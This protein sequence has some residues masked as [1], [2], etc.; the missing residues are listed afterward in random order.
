MAYMPSED[1]SVNDI[2]FFKIDEATYDPKTD[3]FGSDM[4]IA[5]NSSWTVTIP[6]NIKPG[7]YV[8]RHEIIGLHFA[9]IEN[10]EK[11]SSGA[12]PYPNCI[13]T[14]RKLGILGCQ[15]RLLVSD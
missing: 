10:A 8:V 15:P 9:W 13:S 12:Q 4:L 1:T 11:K 2:D 6:S 5:K 14:C 7:T 3:A